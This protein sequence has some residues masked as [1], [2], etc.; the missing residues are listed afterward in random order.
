QDTL[1]FRYTMQKYA[2]RAQGFL[3]N[4]VVGGSGNTTGINTGL[5]HIHVFGPALVNE[6]RFGYN[7]TRVG[8]EMLVHDNILSEFNI[9]G[10]AVNP[11]G[12]GYPQMSI[13]NLTSTAPARTIASFPSPFLLVENS[14][15]FLDTVSWHKQNH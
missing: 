2:A 15:Q 7:R 14:F 4:E 13:R 12:A 9:P 1:M 3:P 5:A 8:N 6:A 10:L 11:V